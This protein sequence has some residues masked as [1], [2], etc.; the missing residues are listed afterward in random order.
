VRIRIIAGELGGRYIEAPPGRR[1]RPTAERVREAWFSALGDRLE[2]ATVVDLF[3]GSGAL[4]LE[5]LSR[6]AARVHFVETDR[7]AAESIRRNVQDLGVRDRSRLVRR[8]VFA[9]LEQCSRT[10][11]RFDLALADPPYTGAAASRL[12]ERFEDDPFAALLC[13]E[14][15]AGELAAARGAPVRVSRYGDTELTWLADRAGWVTGD[16]VD[17]DE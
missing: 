10:G 7:R 5:A 2:G 3:A 17:E 13:V 15:R 16:R 9:Y 4:G 11:R 8:D 14:H 6:G 12:V 1:T